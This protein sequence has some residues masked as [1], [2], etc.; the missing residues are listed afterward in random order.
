MVAAVA[1]K[2]TTNVSIQTFL[3]SRS[4]KPDHLRKWGHGAG[5]KF[6]AALVRQ[7]LY[8]W[9]SGLR[10]AIDWKQLIAARRS[11]GKKHLARFPRSALLTKVR[12]LLQDHAHASLLDGRVVETVKADSWWFR[13]WEDEYGLSMK[14]ANRK[15]SVPRGVLKERLEL[16]WVTV[17]RLRQLMQLALGYDPL[18]LN[19]D[20]SP[21]HHNETGS[22]DKPCLAAR[23]ANVPVVEGTFDVRSRWTANL[24]TMSRFSAVAGGAMPPAE[25]MFKAE[26]DGTVERSLQQ[27]LRSGGYPSWFSVAVGTK[28]SYREED[29]IAF[30]QKHL[31]PMEEGRDWRILLADDYRVHKTANVFALCWSRG[32]V[33]VIHGGGATPVA[34]TC[35]TDLN[36]HVR[37]AYGDKESR[38]LIEKMRSG[39]V[40]PS[41]SNEQ[42]VRCMFEVL[43]DVELHKKAA[44]G[45]KKVGQSVDLHGKED[46]LICREAG[47]YW[48]EETTDGYLTMRGRIDAEL[49]AVAEEYESKRIAWCLRDVKRLIAPYPQRKEVDSVLEKL[50]DE[51]YLDDIHDMEDIAAVADGS[52]SDSSDD[53]DMEARV[54]EDLTH[55][56]EHAE[57]NAEDN[58]TQETTKTPTTT[59]D[60]KDDKD[61]AIVPLGPEQADAVH[62]ANITIA[63]LQD[64]LESLRAAGCVRGLQ[65]IEAEVA[66]ERRRVRALS[67]ESPAVAVCFLRLRRAEEQRCLEAARAVA[68]QNARKRAADKAIC[69]RNAAVAEEKAAKKRLLD[70]EGTI[71]CKHAVKTFLL[72]SLGAGEKNA[73]GGKG[74]KQRLEVLDR[75]RRI[76]AGLS[77]G[78][79]NDW[80]WFSD[81]W[82]R[83]MVAEHGAGWAALFA[84][85][86][87]GVLNDTRSNAFSLFV[88]KETLRVFHGAAAL[89]VPGG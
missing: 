2:P 69:D 14:R 6:K 77:A 62:S 59:C 81:A 21:F 31:E 34:Q 65:C 67:V 89:H 29:L 48:N 79:K 88:H 25:C 32:Y 19:F 8:E 74:R 11:R 40:V 78:Q 60:S 26:K 52:D 23:G 80:A 10:Y 33:L 41:L 49:A 75:L 73:G 36:Q 63:A 27:H 18:I 58:A 5:P 61:E 45:F 72:D 15:F 86:M 57:H 30:L 82:D 44:E 85:W 7:A 54:E 3:K 46:C 12:Q 64:A 43:S 53:L 17:F 20:Q 13:R 55:G 47:V 28:G 68:D 66:K 22:Q 42:C 87:Q 38:L 4:R 70:T 37:R 50:A 39:A 84:Q 76:G 71:A 51:A 56:G 16:C 83:A 1:G 35:D 24:M 9:W